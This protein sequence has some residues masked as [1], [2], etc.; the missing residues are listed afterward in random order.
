MKSN[1]KK[2]PSTS[3][4]S[5]RQQR[6]S[7]QRRKD[8]QTRAIRVVGILVALVGLMLMVFLI[9][10]R[11]EA[12]NVGEIEG[13]EV[14][15]NL[16]GGH[17]SQPVDYP[18]NPPVGGPHNS[19]WQNCGVY[20][21]S[22]ANENAVHSLEHGAIWITYHPD[23]AEADVQELETLTRQ[24]GYRLLSQYPDLPAEIVLSAW[25]YQLQLEQTDDP[26]LTDFFE[27]YEQNPRGPE[28][29]APCTGGIGQPS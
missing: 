7:A 12:E 13:V 19:A 26:R 10:S 24:S 27:K 6:R 28:P 17:T 11:D 5:K 25:G 16:T 8:L 14:F 15:P 22:V 3:P 9:S 4:A 21:Q 2:P 18:Q 29:G 1:S 20:S 23:L